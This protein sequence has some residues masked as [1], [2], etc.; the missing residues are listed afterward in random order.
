M[1]LRGLLPIRGGIVSEVSKIFLY[2]EKNKVEVVIPDEQLSLAIG[3]EYTDI[4]AKNIAKDFQ[5]NQETDLL[6]SIIGNIIYTASTHNTLEWHRMGGKTD[7]VESC[8]K[9]LSNTKELIDAVI[10]SQNL[11][12]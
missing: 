6:P 12:T 11:S 5:M 7:L 10:S 9:M 2:E 8:K 4:L 3:N 1:M